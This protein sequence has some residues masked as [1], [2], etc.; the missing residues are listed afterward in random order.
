MELDFDKI[1]QGAIEHPF[2]II[3]AVT[4]LIIFLKRDGL[5]NFLK[6][7][8]DNRNTSLDK[9]T[10][11]LSKIQ[12]RYFNLYENSFRALEKISEA[13]VSFKEGLLSVEDRLNTKIDQEM[14]EIRGEI[15]DNRIEQLSVYIKEKQKSGS[16]FSSEAKQING[17]R[18]S[19]ELWRGSVK[20][21]STPTEIVENIPSNLM[22]SVLTPGAQAQSAQ[23]Q[24][25]SPSQK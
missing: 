1:L 11:E 24:S 2:A 4:L 21:T 19:T 14:E 10:D 7:Y 9:R 20:I 25:A 17:D 15:R 6:S 12:D 8:L 3:L 5:A 16:D 23:A 18:V 22:Q 13:I